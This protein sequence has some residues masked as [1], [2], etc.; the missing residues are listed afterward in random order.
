MAQSKNQTH[1]I[2]Q[3]ML[4]DNPHTNSGVYST[5]QPLEQT[6]KKHKSEVRSKTLA[7]QI[8]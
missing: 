1:F 3:K 2:V 5:V 6:K 8:S 7:S 4:N